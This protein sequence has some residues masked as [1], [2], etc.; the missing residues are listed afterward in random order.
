[1]DSNPFFAI[2]NEIERARSEMLL[3]EQILMDVRAPPGSNPTFRQRLRYTH[4]EEEAEALQET[5]RTKLANLEASRLL[6][7]DATKC[8]Q[9]GITNIQSSILA[10]RHFFTDL[11]NLNNLISVVAFRG[12]HLT[13]IRNEDHLLVHCG[14]VNDHNLMA[15]LQISRGVDGF[16]RLQPHDASSYSYLSVT[17]SILDESRKYVDTFL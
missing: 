13:F 10:Q 7:N 9:Q 5:R 11:S 14:F 6:F 12:P 3:V 17:A 1:M 16:L 4:R 15:C 2:M 8:L